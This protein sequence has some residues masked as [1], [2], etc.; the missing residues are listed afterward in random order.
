MATKAD[1]DHQSAI[2]KR[3]LEALAAVTKNDL[4][5]HAAAMKSDLDAHAA[6]MKS[7]LDVLAAATKS[8]LHAHAATMK[9]D[10]LA[11]DVKIEAV[12]NDLGA[13]IEISGHQ[14]AENLYRE[15]AAT[16][17]TLV[18]ACVGAVMT[19]SGLAFAAARF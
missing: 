11:L 14:A 6:T 10:L 5:A 4:D 8:D 13:R 9:S 12:R 16:T 18:F 15:L 19:S 3:D 2:T 1:L 7:D 17:R